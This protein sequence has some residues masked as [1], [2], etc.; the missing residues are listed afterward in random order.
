MSTP[1]PQSALSIR[2]LGKS[3]GAVKA[4]QDVSFDLAHG[5]VVGLL[6]DNGAGKS[7]LA[8]CIA[9]VLHPDRGHIAVNGSEVQIQS[10]HHA[11]DLGIETVHQGLALVAKLDVASNLFLNREILHPNPLLR[12]MGWLDKAAMR[13]QCAEILARIG[14]KVAFTDLAVEELSGGQRQAVAIGRAVG[15][16][17]NIVLMDEPTAALGVEQSRQVNALIKTLRDQGVAILLISHNMQH[18][19]ETCDRAVVL[20]HGMKVAD[21]KIAEVTPTDLVGLITGARAA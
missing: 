11:R 12:L 19:V 1:A 5:E 17:R 20:R 3:F 9:G 10:P 2:Q 14:A 21:V 13:R 18:V 6:G 15:W 4:L 7:T 8:K 16:G